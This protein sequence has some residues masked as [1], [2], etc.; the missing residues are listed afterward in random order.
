MLNGH[1]LLHVETAMLLIKMDINAILL[2]DFRIND[3]V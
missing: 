1:M 3:F 2:T